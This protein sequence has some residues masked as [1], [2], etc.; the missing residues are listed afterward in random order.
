MKIQ[1]D[2]LPPSVSHFF[3]QG[4]WGMARV[5]RP[6]LKMLLLLILIQWISLPL[7]VIGQTPS[8]TPGE[9]Y[10][11]DLD[12]VLKSIDG[13]TI[14]DRLGQQLPF[15]TVVRTESA[16]QVSLGTVLDSGLPMIFNPVYFSCPMLCNLVV[17][18][19]IESVS[20]CGLKIGV[21][22]EVV[23]ISIDPR[24]SAKDARNRQKLLITALEESATLTG[25][26]VSGAE[27]GWHFLTGQQASLTAI[28]DA[29]GFEYR[30]NEYNSEYAHGAGIFVVSPDGVLSQTLK[31]I[32]FEPQTVRLALVEASDGKV[33]NWLDEFVLTCFVYDPTK[34][35]YGPA[36]LKVMRLGG[37]VT[38]LGIC[39]YLLYSWTRG[40]RD[41]DPVISADQQREQPQS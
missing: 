16:E 20:Q 36:A 30:W 8:V 28:T 40:G 17:E 15:E 14:H 11:Q 39:S 13:L 35:Q 32:E 31:G 7:T 2:P 26:D 5:S 25:A 9:I 10:N 6:V 23:T 1:K 41:G 37:L 38:V 27:A 4:S 12:P 18:G 3:P 21:D 19:L 34:A 22:F 24:D 29:L 33:G